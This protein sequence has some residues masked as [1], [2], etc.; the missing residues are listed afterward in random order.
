MVGILHFS[1]HHP[2]LPPLIPLLSSRLVRYPLKDRSH[3]RL[4]PIHFCLKLRLLVPEF[5]M[6]QHIPRDVEQRTDENVVL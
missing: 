6:L 5:L 1:R 4:L 3:T 2:S